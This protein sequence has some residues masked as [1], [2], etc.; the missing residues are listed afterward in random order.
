MEPTKEI[1]IELLENEIRLHENT[2]YILEIRHKVN[3]KI[4]AESN[5]LE[6]IAHEM[7]QHNI[8]IDELNN[9]LKE[10]KKMDIPKKKE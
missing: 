5:V 7:T 4:G 3:K 9:L 1:K 10:L 6:N 8:A 2:L